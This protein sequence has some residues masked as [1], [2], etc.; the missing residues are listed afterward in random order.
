MPNANGYWHPSDDLALYR[1]KTPFEFDDY[2]QPICIPMHAVPYGTDCTL[3]GWGKSGMYLCVQ[4]GMTI[5]MCVFA[6]HIWFIE[7]TFFL[8]FQ[9]LC[10]WQSYGILLL[11]SNC[12]ITNK[13]HFC[14]N[15]IYLNIQWLLM[16]CAH[17]K[18][19]TC[20]FRNV[21]WQQCESVQTA[22]GLVHRPH[23]KAVWRT[24]DC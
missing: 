22:A 5:C 12:Q 11:D 17:I 15:L 23:S 20:V 19:D 18:Q 1:V 16:F 13:R 8:H 3:P 2:V 4:M 9:T 24:C 6:G 14:K 10:Q 7:V 21:L